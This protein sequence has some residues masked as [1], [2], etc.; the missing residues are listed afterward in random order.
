MYIGVGT[1]LVILA[2][3]IVLMLLRGRRV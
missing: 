3:V 1:V 2:V